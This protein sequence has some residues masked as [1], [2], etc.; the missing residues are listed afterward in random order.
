MTIG[1]GGFAHQVTV[2]MH[3]SECYKYMHKIKCS[4]FRDFFSRKNITRINQV[5]GICLHAK[6]R[7]F[8]SG[9]SE[10]AVVMSWG[11]VSQSDRSESH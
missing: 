11:S 4:T 3:T 9:R 1:H 6:V 7:Q 10:R 2:D 5:F 8:T